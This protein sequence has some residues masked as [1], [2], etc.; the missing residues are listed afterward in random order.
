MDRLSAVL[1]DAGARGTIFVLPA[2]R[3]V[4]I[5]GSTA[6]AEVAGLGIVEPLRIHE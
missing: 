6:P 3:W 5:P 4:S 1:R 2:S